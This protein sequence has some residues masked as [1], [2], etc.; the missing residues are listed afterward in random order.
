MTPDRA[1]RAT[2][3]SR[4]TRRVIEGPEAA[5]VNERRLREAQARADRTAPTCA[6][7]GE[8]ERRHD[9]AGHPFRGAWW[10]HAIARLETATIMTAMIG[11]GWAFWL[12]ATTPD[13]PL[14][15]LTGLLLCFWDWK[16]Q[17]CR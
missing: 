15:R 13:A 4:A 7:C 8:I 11:I 10:Q 16:G 14:H 5:G 17:L 6:T 1:N 12:S 9:A 3:P 2:G